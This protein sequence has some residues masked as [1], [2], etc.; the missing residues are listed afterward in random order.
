MYL[1]PGPIL[2]IS[3]HSW[4]NSLAFPLR[5]SEHVT[6]AAKTGKDYFYKR[7][8]S[9]FLYQVRRKW[10]YPVSTTTTSSQSR[11]SEEFPHVPP[12]GSAS[13]WC[14][15]VSRDANSHSVVSRERAASK[16]QFLLNL[17]NHAEDR[18]NHYIT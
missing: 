14:F 11:P 12:K 5:T 18:V 13:E 16:R 10:K 6:L 1:L 9:S 8:W 3:V 7:K 2:N 17:W 15:S 4:A